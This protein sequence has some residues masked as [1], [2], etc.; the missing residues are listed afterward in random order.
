[1][2][3]MGYFFLNSS[4]D[5]TESGFSNQVSAFPFSALSVRRSILSSP[6]SPHA[7]SITANEKWYHQN[8]V[9]YGNSAVVNFNNILIDDVGRLVTN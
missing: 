2:I 5:G 3:L 6:Y 8:V 7:N 9:E 4:M 1:M